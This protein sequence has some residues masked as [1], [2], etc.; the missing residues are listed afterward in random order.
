[1]SEERLARY[2][3][4]LSPTI[5]HAGLV[6]LPYIA[7]QHASALLLP[8]LQIVEVCL[9]N[10]LN[11]SL[12]EYFTENPNQHDPNFWY[13][14][15]IQEEKT[16]EKINKAINKARDEVRARPTCQ[17]DIVS[18]LN[19]A[20]WMA[21]I[22][23]IKADRYLWRIISDKV[24]SGI[25]KQGRNLPTVRHMVDVLKDINTT[26]NRLSHHEPIWTDKNVKSMDDAEQHIK[27]IHDKILECL[28]WMSVSLFDIYTSGGIKYDE[29]FNTS[30][31]DSFNFC[32]GISKI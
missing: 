27:E 11:T 17:G 21:I 10:K 30:L 16:K 12:V 25:P 23:E 6:I 18:R 31:E 14:W 13:S 2:R 26:R 29:V 22:Q 7:I 3:I 5:S 28:S 32:R 20:T 15:L 19:F 8:S 4:F 1:M 9:R 24:F